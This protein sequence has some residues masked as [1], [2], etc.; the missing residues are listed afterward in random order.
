[1]S[2]NI[3]PPKYQTTSLVEPGFFASVKR[4]FRR[5]IEKP[6]SDEEI[7][8]LDQGPQPPKPTVAITPAN[9]RTLCGDFDVAC[10]TKETVTKTIDTATNTL[11]SLAV[12]IGI[13]IV[14]GFVVFI[15]AKSFIAKKAEGLA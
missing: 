3:K 8:A 14:I 10:K 1:M 11:Q 13:F 15:F 12:R 4:F 5:N 9:M 6:F 7:R 2:D